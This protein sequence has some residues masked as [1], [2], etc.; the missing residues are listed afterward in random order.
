MRVSLE[1]LK[2][3]VEYSLPPGELADLL[4]MSGSAVDRVIKMGSETS[5]VVVGEVLEVKPHPNADRLRLAVVY[6]GEVQREIVCGAPNLVQGMKSAFAR[7]GASL[8]SIPGGTLKSANIR[9]VE[10]NG[11]LCSGV[12]LGINEDRSGILVLEADAAPGTAITELVPTED[13]VFD[14]EITPN[15]PDCMS[16][17]GIARE[18]AALTGGRLIMPPIE[19]EESD[20]SIGDFAT[21]AVE[22]NEG[23]PRYNARVVSGVGIAPSPLWMQRRLIA[24]GLRPI[25]NIVDIT[26]YI[27]FELGQPLHAFDLELL[28]D[29]KIVVRK[30]GYGEQITTLDGVERQLDDKTLVIADSKRPVALAGVMGGEDSEVTDN[31]RNIL[32]ESAHFNPTSIYLTS[33]RLGI[34]TESSSRFEKGSD[35]EGAPTGASRAAYL[36]HELA[37]GTVAKGSLDVYPVPVV[38]V[39]IELR[40][41]RANKVLGTGLEPGVM[42]EIL[43]SLEA[44]VAEGDR[45][46]VTVP[47]F[48]WDLEREID[49]IEEIGRI[50]GY[51]K[52]TESIPVGGGL[53]S[54]FSRRQKLERRIDTVLLAQGLSEV[55]VYSFMNEADLDL[56]RITQEDPMRR[57]LPVMNPLAETGGVMR[58]TLIPGLL[59][60]AVRN[61]NRGNRNISIFE[62]GRV[63]LANASGT[64]PEEIDVVGIL[65]AGERG[66][67]NWS[68]ENP[69][70]DFFDLKGIM[71]QVSDA[72]GVKVAYKPEDR[73]YLTP[74][75]SAGMF[76]FHDMVGV[77]GRLHPEVADAFGLEDEIYIG[78]FATAPFIDA[79]GESEYRRVGRFPN[80]KV[81]IALIVEESLAASSVMEKIEQ[82]G[83]EYL[84]SVRLF[85][86]YK[87]S[88]IPSGKKSLAFALEFG[89][90][91]GT[92]TDDQAHGELERIV[93]A[94]QEAYSAELRGRISS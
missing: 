65:L 27:L 25:N 52:I 87:G 38:P 39:T 31:T 17:V 19:C 3:Y 66:E 28:N 10:S 42:A 48:R 73:P 68:A 47:S 82:L 74:G 71:E 94:V 61:I 12:E 46:S 40:P 6:D 90:A 84:V 83:G 44:D 37:G 35:P 50:Y 53:E 1:W 34:R 58:S 51:D 23:C 11:M 8:Q 14:L 64:L 59:N 43:K 29:R 85:D 49:L 80:V 93:D 76:I 7:L 89:S 62:R 41:E 26:N 15:R 4:S 92:L 13:I 63:F 21:V 20:Q 22:D 2:D 91:E 54:G 45:L 79:A 70:Y 78:E 69:R 67:P 55:V 60:T 36:M 56:L 72:L 57:I 18:V 75:Q 32:I 88:Q 30:A 33:K 77:F 24:A 16:M 86:V 81:D 9:G 5:G